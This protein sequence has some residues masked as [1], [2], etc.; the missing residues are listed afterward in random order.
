MYLQKFKA[1]VSLASILEAV[2]QVL[3]LRL[4]IQ[5]SNLLLYYLKNQV[6]VAITG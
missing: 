3:L 5:A 6:I 4:S 2:E 1:T